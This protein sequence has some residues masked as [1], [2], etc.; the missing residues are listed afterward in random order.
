MKKKIS[1]ILFLKSKQF[2]VPFQF[3]NLSDV[4]PDIFEQIISDPKHKYYVKSD[5]SESI[6][7]SFI[8]FWVQETK[9][10]VNIENY[11][12]YL[13]LSQEFCLMQEFLSSTKSN[14]SEYEQNI[15]ILNDP[16][17]NDKSIIEQQVAQNLDDYIENQGERLMRLNIQTLYNIF[18]HKNKKFT[19]HD[20]TYELI[21]QRYN[22]NQDGNIFILLRFI[23]AQKIQTGHLFDSI[24]NSEQRC[25]YTPNFDLSILEVIKKIQE[26]SKEQEKTIQ[27][28][29][30]SCEEQKQEIEKHIKTIE[31]LKKN[32]EFFSNFIEKQENENK[33]LR[34]VIENIKLQN[35][36]FH[37]ELRKQ[38]ECNDLINKSIEN[39]IISQEKNSENLSKQIDDLKNCIKKEFDKNEKYQK[40]STMKQQSNEKLIDEQSIKNK[41]KVD[42]E[43]IL[44]Q[45]EKNDEYN[46]IDC[47]NGFFKYLFDKYKA[48]PI[49][50]GLINIDGNS[51]AN[52]K[53]HYLPYIINSSYSDYYNSEDNVNSYIT[54][55]FKSF[56]L[57]FDK[58]SLT[59]GDSSN[60]QLFKS[61]ILKGITN[62]N[63][64]I[65][66]DNVNNL[67]EITQNNPK[68][69]RMIKIQNIPFVK[70]IHLQMKEKNTDNAYFMCLKNI[71]FFGVFKYAE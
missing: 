40:T 24:L 14:W 35:N 2:E 20:R 4:N 45:S 1:F 58:Y 8:N 13:Q 3:K 11:Y 64:E 25:G 61:W 70:S 17:I 27:E 52:N 29:K 34:A 66:L 41:T 71:E 21:H 28:L 9:P 33:E 51:D 16:M 55:D 44:K 68:I 7:E 23:E 36:N 30:K 54:I 6:F 10:E 56:L 42:T 15:F 69:T 26:Q 50:K 32:C 37:D 43:N 18:N 63:K 38:K 67:K 31:E 65:I 19:K 5:V 59:V 39:K 49:I 46:L 62:E 22:E 57:K 47:S 12:Q 53:K 60:E 48:N